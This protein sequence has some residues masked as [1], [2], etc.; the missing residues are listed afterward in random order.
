MQQLVRGKQLESGLYP[1]ELIVR[2][3]AMWFSPVGRAQSSRRQEAMN[4][5]LPPESCGQRNR[6][7]AAGKL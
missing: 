5:P 2:A 6:V 3:S 1:A 4:I 7:W